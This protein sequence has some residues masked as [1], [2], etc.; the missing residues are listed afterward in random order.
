MIMFMKISEILVITHWDVHGLPTFMAS[1]ASVIE[2]G[3]SAIQLRLPGVSK[4]EYAHIASLTAKAITGENISLFL[5]CEIDD[6]PDVPATGIH[7]KSA[8]AAKL[9]KIPDEF[10]Q[11]YLFSTPCHN[12]QEI[13]HANALGVDFGIITPVKQSFKCPDK[14]AI[15]WEQAAQLRRLSSIPMYAAGGLTRNDLALALELGFSGVAGIGSFFKE[16]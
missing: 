8:S 15:G 12:A 5:N 6:I 4:Q 10:R 3:Y 9:K 7:L 13:N 1:L 14:H 16:Y 11:Q 2:N